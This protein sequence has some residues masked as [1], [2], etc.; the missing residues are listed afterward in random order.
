ML[1]LIYLAGLMILLLGAVTVW[2]GAGASAV[3]V[4]NLMNFLDLWTLA[5][6]AAFCLLALLAAGGLK[7]FGGAM[8]WMFKREALPV[9]LL[10]ERLLAVRTAVQAAMLGG[11]FGFAASLVNLLKW[12]NLSE[13]TAELGNGIGTALLFLIYPLVIALVLLP[14]YAALKK[15]LA[16]GDA[17]EKPRHTVSVSRSAGKK[18]G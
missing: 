1:Y 10:K 14:V 7:A 8:A 13:G 11:G 5:V 18:A 15:A 6:I 2:T 4:S 12:L 9:P 17:A 16:A 3:V